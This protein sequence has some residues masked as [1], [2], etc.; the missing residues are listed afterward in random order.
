MRLDPSATPFAYGSIGRPAARRNLLI[1][2]L[3][4]TVSAKQ[5]ARSQGL[6]LWRRRRAKKLLKLF[7][8]IDGQFYWITGLGTTHLFVPPC[9]S[10][11]SAQEAVKPG[12]DL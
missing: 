11:S 8:F 5:D 1:A 10:L 4:M 12:R 2:L 6:C 7:R 9:P 3:W